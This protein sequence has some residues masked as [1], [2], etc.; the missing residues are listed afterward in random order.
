[1]GE[2]R[3]PLPA[4]VRR[5]GRLRILLV[6]DFYPPDSGGLEAHARRLARALLT[7]GHEV[8]VATVAGG[9]GLPAMDDG[10]RVAR[11]PT[12]VGRLKPLYRDRSRPFHP[13]WPDPAFTRRL[14]RLAAAFRPDVVH[15]HGWCAFSA[16]A[17][18]R[19]D[20]PLVVTLHDYGLRCPKKTLLR[21][22]RECATGRGTACLTCP[23]DE[24]GPARRAALA[25]ALAATA[26][27]LDRGVARF[28]AVSEHV[29][30]RHVEGGLDPARV[31]VVPNF[32][33][34]PADAEPPAAG[35]GPAAGVLYVG[36][37]AAHKGRAVL[38]EAHR[39][40]PAGLARLVVVGDGGP[41]APGV[42]Y[43]GRLDGDALWARYRAAAVV[44]VPSVWPEPCPTVALEAMGWGRPLV[45]SRTGGLLDLVADGDSGVLVPPGD[46]A[47]LAAALRAL[48]EDG[49]RRRAMGTAALARAQAF[50]TDAVVPR[51]EAIYREVASREAAATAAT[52]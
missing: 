27:R 7:R 19:P 29:A 5:G 11:W 6:A 8:A 34:M 16:L 44:V 10:V 49:G 30:A 41:D 25:V 43:A 28:L 32:L 4:G 35:D 17:A 1:M 37:A 48:L 15:A 21:G 22:G 38:L 42:E 45:A 31:R 52:P 12:S 24:Q 9:A 39:R 33:D 13:P 26:G 46:P 40:L 23:R 2:H 50:S 36:P 3:R 51:I 14:G 20:A 47:A 18:S